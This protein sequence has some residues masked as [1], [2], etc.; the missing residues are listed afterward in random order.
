MLAILWLT[1]RG[2]PT[3][4][5]CGTTDA[6]G[7]SA[8]I[9]PALAPPPPMQSA[10][11]DAGTLAVRIDGDKRV[12][13]GTVYDQSVEGTHLLQAANAV[14]GETNIVDKLA[15]DATTSFRNA[16]TKPMRC[17]PR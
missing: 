15:V 3:G 13:E 10:A 9:E 16:P 14:F 12:L 4:T 5:C 17:S 11:K 7:A 8:P 1:G 6:N 2:P